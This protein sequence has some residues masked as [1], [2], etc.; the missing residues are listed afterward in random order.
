MV[1]KVN[2]ENRV[3]LVW[4]FGPGALSFYIVPAHAL[5]MVGALNRHR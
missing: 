4:P 5:L 1:E 3:T 2:K